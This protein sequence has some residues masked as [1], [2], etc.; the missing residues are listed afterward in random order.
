MEPTTEQTAQLARELEARGCSD[1]LPVIAPHTEGCFSILPNRGDPYASVGA[2]RL[3]GDPDL[4]PDFDWP[5]RS[6]EPF[7]G[8]AAFIGQIRLDA[9]PAHG[10][11]PAAGL[12]SIFCFGT[13]SAADPVDVAVQLFTDCRDLRRRR[14]DA[15]E[16]ADE[17][18]RGLRP[19]AVDLAPAIDVDW[20]VLLDPFAGRDPSLYE[21]LTDLRVALGSAGIGQLLGFALDHDKTD[22]RVEVVLAAEG[23]RD[24]EHETF[25]RSMQQ[26]REMLERMRAERDRERE[27]KAGKP[28][29]YS[30]RYKTTRIEELERKAKSIRWWV[31]NRRRLLAEARRW[32]S[33]LRVDSNESMDLS[34][35]DADPLFVFAHETELAAGRFT[36][37]TGRVLQG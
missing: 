1:L 23:R 37:P 34:I 26:Y 29:D 7:A 28:Q 19:V 3:G 20:S 16:I 11:L 36:R 31:D 15:S 2:H 6:E 27:E 17:Y 10:P 14:M 4:P 12:L 24:I 5:T 32:H 25:I 35:N 8:R 18:L 33:L 22:L 30:L 9:L 21:R 13:E